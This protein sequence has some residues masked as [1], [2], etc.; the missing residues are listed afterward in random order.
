[1]E[2]QMN[3]MTEENHTLKEKIAKLEAVV[4]EKDLHIKTIMKNNEIAKSIFLCKNNIFFSVFYIF[5]VFSQNKWHNTKRN[6]QFQYIKQSFLE[7]FPNAD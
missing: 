2:T 4:A 6:V 5:L 1:M 3:T 7:K